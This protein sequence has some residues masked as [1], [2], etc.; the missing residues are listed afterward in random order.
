MLS[1]TCHHAHALPG[2]TT[3]SLL[4]CRR[5]QDRN[6]DGRQVLVVL[7]F[8]ATDV[9]THLTEVILEGVTVWKGDAC[10]QPLGM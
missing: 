10:L 9:L 4:F 8:D 3:I 5:C 2:M 6:G 1:L 7:S